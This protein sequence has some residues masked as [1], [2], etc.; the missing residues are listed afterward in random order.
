MSGETGTSRPGTEAVKPVMGV[1]LIL[2]AIA[3]AV[4]LYQGKVA[5]ALPLIA[6]GL[7]VMASTR[8]AM[9]RAKAKNKD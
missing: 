4:L 9:T 2:L 3:C 5:I 1:M 7:A 8:A 6:V